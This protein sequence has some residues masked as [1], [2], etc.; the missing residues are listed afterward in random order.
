MNFHLEVP[1]EMTMQ[2]R[3][4][5]KICRTITGSPEAIGAYIESLTKFG[6]YAERL[7]GA[8][9]DV[10]SLMETKKPEYR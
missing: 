4:R 5:G 9:F 1:K 2:M 8:V 3:N 6:A 7:G 10:T